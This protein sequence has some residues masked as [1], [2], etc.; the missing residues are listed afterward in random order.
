MSEPRRVL[1]RCG[2][3][4]NFLCPCGAV[5]RHLKRLGL[6]YRTERVARRRSRRPEIVELTQLP[7]VPVLVDGDE[8]ITDSTR[9][10]HWLDE[11]FPERP[12]FPADPQLAAHVEIFIDWFNRAW[13]REPNLIADAL[14][15]GR[16][17]GEDLDRWTRRLQ[18]R[19]DL[20]E[21]MLTGRE[22]LFGEFGAADCAAWPFLRYAVGIDQDDPWT[23]HKVIHERM[24]LQDRHRNVAAWIARMR[25]R[26]IA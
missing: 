2:T 15:A 4:T 16:G 26:P 25:E 12:V 18:R 14:D 10:M 3:P 24:P 9:I 5:A 20:F 11:R 7:Y 1:Y 17:E 19:L 13:K 21:G 23:F 8:V 22:Y 6:E